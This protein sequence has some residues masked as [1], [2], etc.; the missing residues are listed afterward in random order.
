M[1]LQRLSPHIVKHVTRIKNVMLHTVHFLTSSTL[2]LVLK[3][4]N[5]TKNENQSQ[6][7]IYYIKIIDCIL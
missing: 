4:I 6:D 1:I 7:L 5:K 2:V 3:T